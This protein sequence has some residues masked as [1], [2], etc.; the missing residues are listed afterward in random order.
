MWSLKI[1]WKNSTHTPDG[2]VNQCSNDPC[3]KGG[4]RL[5]ST[6]KLGSPRSNETSF[7]IR[8][9]GTTYARMLKMN[10]EKTEFCPVGV[11]LLREAERL[12]VYAR[13]RSDWISN[14]VVIVS[15]LGEDPVEATSWN[16]LFSLAKFRVGREIRRDEICS[17]DV[18]GDAAKTPPFPNELA[19]RAYRE[20]YR[21]KW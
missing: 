10:T 18:V 7:S 2:E 9:K 4:R 3:Q 15:W 14:H 17:Y 20:F 1:Y 5:S 19:G 6:W 8:K 13:T 16:Q 11:L 12:T 21:D